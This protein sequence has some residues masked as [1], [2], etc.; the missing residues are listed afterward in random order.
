MARHPADNTAVVQRY[1]LKERRDALMELKTIHPSWTVRKWAK[2][3]GCSKSTIHY[4][5]KAIELERQKRYA[6]LKQGQVMQ[7]EDQLNLIIEESWEA[8]YKS[9]DEQKIDTQGATR[10]VRPGADKNLMENAPHELKGSIKRWTEAGDSK[11]LLV[12][13][14]CVAQLR[15]LHN[16]DAK[17]EEQV[18]ERTREI[19]DVFLQTAQSVFQAEGIPMR[20]VARLGAALSRAFDIP[21][22]PPLDIKAVETTP[23]KQ[24]RLNGGST[25]GK[26]K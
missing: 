6:H 11:Y 24:P 19:A 23:A 9:L 18:I 13:A 7:V 12:I 8:W 5:I 4:D 1:K 16:L 25:N 15:A 2:H 26:A 17:P 22:L 21:E 10:T 3:F 14:N 20:V